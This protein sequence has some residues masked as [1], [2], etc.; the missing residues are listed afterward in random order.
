MGD[1]GRRTVVVVTA[2]HGR[3]RDYRD[4]GGALPESAR[5][6]L[7]A[8]GGPVRSRGMIDGAEPRHL[9]DVAPTIRQMVGLPTIDLRGGGTAISE[10]FAGSP[11]AELSRR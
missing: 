1:R 9:A 2:D 11:A 5:V 7:M 10:L 3:G 8:I 6:W 4:H